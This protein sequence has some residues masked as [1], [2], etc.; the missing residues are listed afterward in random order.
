[1]TNQEAMHL[2]TCFAEERGGD[3]TLEAM[4]EFLSG[5]VTSE[6]ERC[7][8]LVNRLAGC[9]CCAGIAT[10][11]R[12]GQTKA[13]EKCASGVNFSYPWGRRC[14][15]R[16]FPPQEWFRRSPRRRRTAGGV[17]ADRLILALVLGRG[18]RFLCARRKRAGI[19][20]VRRSGGFEITCASVTVRSAKAP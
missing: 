9:E 12:G 5:L 16:P 2:W 19:R 1:M 7:A 14:P 8:S 11:I 17:V 10:V 18:R 6:R 15:R 13:P 3:V 4:G 20:L